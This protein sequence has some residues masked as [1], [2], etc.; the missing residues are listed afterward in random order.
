M[1]RF[2]PWHPTCLCLRA[3]LTLQSVAPEY[4]QYQL[5]DSIQGLSSYLRGILCTQAVL[6]GLGVGQESA[7]AL[8]A[9]LNWVARDGSA[10]LA[11]LVFT[12]WGG[13][14]FDRNLV[15]S[16]SKKE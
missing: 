1:S 5:L 3:P 16:L 14:R 9:T 4:A 10:M 15:R 12:W 2:P 11:G 6:V 8:A 7:T 13:A